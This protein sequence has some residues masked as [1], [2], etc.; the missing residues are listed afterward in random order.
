MLIIIRNVLI[1]L[2]FEQYIHRTIPKLAPDFHRKVVP[3]GMTQYLLGIREVGDNSELANQ[4]I[5]ATLINPL[6]KQTTLFLN[7]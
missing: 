1:V 7:P 6:F 5:P 3:Q 4:A 2:E